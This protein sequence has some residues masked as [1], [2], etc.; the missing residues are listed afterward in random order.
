VFKA[1]E[2]M[3]ETETALDKGWQAMM[4][5]K[6]EISSLV[7]SGGFHRTALMA[8]PQSTNSSHSHSPRRQEF[9]V[10]PRDA[11]GRVAV[12]SPKLRLTF[13]SE[14]LNDLYS[15]Q[16]KTKEQVEVNVSAIK[17]HN[18]GLHEPQAAVLPKVE[19]EMQ[20]PDPNDPK[21]QVLKW[22]L[23]KKYGR[24]AGDLA[25]ALSQV[26]KC[27]VPAL[28]QLDELGP[29]TLTLNS[30]AQ[31]TRHLWPL[32]LSLGQRL[33]ILRKALLAQEEKM[34]LMAALHSVQ[35][36]LVFDTIEGQPEDIVD[37]KAAD[38]LHAHFEL[39]HGEGGFEAR[40]AHMID[41]L[42][43]VGQLRDLAIREA[44][45]LLLKD[46]ADERELPELPEAMLM[47]M[48]IP[49]DRVIKC[50]GSH[51]WR[52][53]L[54]TKLELIEQR[55]AVTAMKMIAEESAKAAGR[56]LYGVEDDSNG[57]VLAQ[58][59]V[60]GALVEREEPAND[61]HTQEV[62]IQRAK[63]AAE[64]EAGYALQIA[65][66][67][68]E[69]IA[70]RYELLRNEEL[71]FQLISAWLEALPA[72]NNSSEHP[73]DAGQS[74]EACVSFTMWREF[75]SV[76]SDLT[77]EDTCFL[78]LLHRGWAASKW[79]EKM[80]S[81][82][83]ETH[84]LPREKRQLEKT[85]YRKAVALSR[86]HKA[87]EE[88]QA[89]M[90]NVLDPLR[91]LSCLPLGQLHPGVENAKG[92]SAHGLDGLP[93]MM[94]K[95]SE[96]GSLKELWLYGNLLK[97]LPP[98][99]CELH[100]LQTLHLECN[101]IPTLPD[102][103]GCLRDLTT[104][105]LSQNQLTDMPGGVGTLGSLRELHLEGNQFVHVPAVLLDSQQPISGSLRIL[106]LHNNRLKGLRPTSE[107]QEPTL[108]ALRKLEV[109]QLQNNHLSMLPQMCFGERGGKAL[110]LRVLLLHNNNLAAVPTSVENLKDLSKLTLHANQLQLT[111]LADDWPDLRRMKSLKTISLHTN[112]ISG[113]PEELS[114]PQASGLELFRRLPV[115]ALSANLL[116][117]LPDCLDV[118]EDCTELDV[119]RNRLRRMPFSFVEMKVL[120]IANLS[121]NLITELPEEIAML[122]HTLKALHLQDNQL[123]VLPR[124]FCQLNQLEVLDVARNAIVNLPKKFHQLQKLSE[125]TLQDNPLE[126]AL[127]SLV[128]GFQHV[129]GGGG[130]GT[131][132]APTE[133]MYRTAILKLIR[134]FE[135]PARQLSSQ[136][137]GRSELLPFGIPRRTYYDSRPPTKARALIATKPR[138]RKGFSGSV[139]MYL[140]MQVLP[141]LDLDEDGTVLEEEFRR[142]FGQLGMWSAKEMDTVLQHAFIDG[143]DEEGRPGVMS[144]GSLN[145]FALTYAVECACLAE[146]QLT[147]PPSM[148]RINCKSFSD[149]GGVYSIVRHTRASTMESTKVAGGQTLAETVCKFM[150]V[151][152]QTAA[153]MHRRRE[154]GGAMYEYDDTDMIVKAQGLQRVQERN[155]KDLTNLQEVVVAFSKQQ[156][157]PD[158][159]EG[160][161]VLKELKEEADRRLGRGKFAKKAG[162]GATI[163]EH[164]GTDRASAVEHE[165]L[166][167]EHEQLLSIQQDQLQLMASM[168]D[169]LRA[170]NPLVEA[171]FARQRKIP[172]KPPPASD[173]AHDTDQQHL[174]AVVLVGGNPSRGSSTSGKGATGK[175]EGAA[176][177]AGGKKAKPKKAKGPPPIEVW[178]DDVASGRRFTITSAREHTVL[179]LKEAIKKQEELKVPTEQLIILFSH[180]HKRHDK[181]QDHPLLESYGIGN[182]T[183]V[184]LVVGTTSTERYQANYSQ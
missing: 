183:L 129:V 161:D 137:T 173:C 61:K 67:E 160:R 108:C 86:V 56:N 74:V 72:D 142:Y 30:S 150:L 154:A 26:R 82:L 88:Q 33:Q 12:D 53:T 125:L 91:S 127:Q 123:T 70:N 16:L 95:L 149:E 181:L 81:S 55:A 22:H 110:P 130:N 155:F 113:L 141:L 13:T 126:D 103:L 11:D 68:V 139:A 115:V 176:K 32:V 175:A 41:S 63:E 4:E 46:D 120:V 106:S 158:L 177:G 1:F 48:T 145:M 164:H 21:L 45:V 117:E 107:G 170:L 180:H 44:W 40:T 76:V 167:R 114:K 138:Q 58:K 5:L 153:E 37:P 101:R 89:M 49:A 54:K 156:G 77:P 165:L 147:L 18:T 52:R 159:T 92:I 75:Y 133:R 105:N 31:R 99:V 59:K 111:K 6:H 102:G 87:C 57:A 62:K 182:G 7:R 73:E 9:M 3:R 184:K 172:I 134:H 69:A 94:A 143:E 178:V 157:K 42:R 20:L 151:R 28:Q 90:D 2:F 36:T 35:A 136:V 66:D 169:Q 17:E 144:L 104:L 118:L 23:G 83:R 15:L 112:N 93:S 122:R 79:R 29:N 85:I 166:L 43:S 168:Q 97:Q 131:F 34:P 171:E 71:H 38:M 135:V 163:T 27:I 8:A 119:E 10:S 148:Q 51:A 100:Q 64:K 162:A 50:Y 84:H 65:Q 60:A 152:E 80:L 132:L 146:D 14:L 140:D 25:T 39:Q 116:T 47:N 109:L 174:A 24:Y 98:V 96:E 179:E 19:G 124:S 128:D 121:A 78:D